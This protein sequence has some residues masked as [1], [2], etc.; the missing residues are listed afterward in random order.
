MFYEKF[1][2]NIFHFSVHVSCFVKCYATIFFTLVFVFHILLFVFHRLVLCSASPSSN[3]LL[4]SSMFSCLRLFFVFI[5]MSLFIHFLDGFYF[6]V[7]FVRNGG[8]AK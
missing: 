8:F 2:Y 6:L 5:C 1:C 7:M 4:H 3:A